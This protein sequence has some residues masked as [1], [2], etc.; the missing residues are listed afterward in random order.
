MNGAVIQP[1]LAKFFGDISQNAHILIFIGIQINVIIGQLVL[2][3]DQAWR[4]FKVHNLNHWTE[5]NHNTDGRP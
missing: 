1:F 4:N 5:L 2:D 3:F